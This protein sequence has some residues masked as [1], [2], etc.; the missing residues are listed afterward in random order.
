VFGGSLEEV[1]GSRCLGCDGLGGFV[2]FVRDLEDGRRTRRKRGDLFGYVLPVDT[3]GAGPEM[4]VLLDEVVVDVEFGDAGPEEL[5]GFVDAFVIFWCGKMRVAQVE[6]DA[7][8]VE[9]ADSYDLKQVLRG[10]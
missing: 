1:E 8:A 9:V 3:C 10:W 7:D 6:G 5:E 2:E 4:V